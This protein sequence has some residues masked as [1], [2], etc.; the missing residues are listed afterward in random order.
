M[1]CCNGHM[2]EDVNTSDRYFTSCSL[3]VHFF[4][5]RFRV[6]LSP[7]WQWEVFSPAWI[8]TFKLICPVNAVPHTQHTNPF[9]PECIIR[10]HITGSPSSVAED[11]CD[12]ALSGNVCVWNFTSV[13]LQ[14]SLKEFPSLHLQSSFKIMW[15]LCD[16]WAWQQTAWI[17]LL[18]PLQPLCILFSSKD[19][20]FI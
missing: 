2:P 11:S 18:F 10:C 15:Q 7:Q 9:L 1:W 17:I 5:S 4:R 13:S 8:L 12:A 3:S 16:H 20:Y 19:N 6:K 14:R